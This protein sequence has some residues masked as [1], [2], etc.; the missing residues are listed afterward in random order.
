MR[1]PV[2]FNSSAI[3]TLANIGPGTNSKDCLR[4]SKTDEPVMSL[5]RRS[6]VNCIRENFPSMEPAMVLASKVFPTPGK[7]SNR[8]CPLGEEAHQS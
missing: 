8:T 7:S 5:G 4:M 2:R 6:E 3:T 1:G